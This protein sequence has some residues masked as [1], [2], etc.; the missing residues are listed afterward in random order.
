[1]DAIFE[2]DE[3]R[4]FARARFNLQHHGKLLSQV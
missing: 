3:T 4:V 1:M 2:C